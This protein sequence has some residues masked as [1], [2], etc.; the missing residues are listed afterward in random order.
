MEQQ[1]E[2]T[3][4]HLGIF[5]QILNFLTNIAKNNEKNRSLFR[6]HLPLFVSTH[7][8]HKII[9]FICRASHLGSE[10]I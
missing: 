9:I 5:T 7:P 6:E 2:W 8:P 1:T 10:L 4:N 3:P